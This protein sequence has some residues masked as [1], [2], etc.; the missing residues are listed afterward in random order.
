MLYLDNQTTGNDA[1]ESTSMFVQGLPYPFTLENDSSAV[2]TSRMR[3]QAGVSGASDVT[4]VG[5]RA[6]RLVMSCHV[7][8]QYKNIAVLSTTVLLQSPHTAATHYRH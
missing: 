1:R 6:P 5:T 7:H 2:Y 4:T 8:E 3:L